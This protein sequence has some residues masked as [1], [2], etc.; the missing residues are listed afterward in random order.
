M[1]KMLKGDG[2]RGHLLG[3][4]KFE[5]PQFARFLGKSFDA[6]IGVRLRK[7]FELPPAQSEPPAI[8]M[9]LQQ[10]EAKLEGRR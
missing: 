9:L 5:T 3:E 2:M 8:R 6:Q 10:I 7:T 1:N 4:S